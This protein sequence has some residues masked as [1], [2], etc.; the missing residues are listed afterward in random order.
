MSAIKLTSAASYFRGLSHQ[1]A[2]WNWL[3]EQL[4]PQQL[5]E[6]AE[7]YRADPPANQRPQPPG[8]WLALCAPLVQSFEGCRLTAYPD[9]GT[10]GDPWTI[11]WGSTTYANGKPVKPGDRIDQA[12][13]DQLLISRLQRDWQTLA[14]RI[15]GWGRMR[16]GQQAAL[17][18]F[19]YNV[20]VGFY[21][22]S[23]FGTISRA[24]SSQDWASV[25][26]A[27]MLYVNPGTSVEAG[28]RR[29]RIAEGTT[30]G[31]A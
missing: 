27:L 20:G 21:Q 18:S 2:A 14:G 28:L 25:P 24:L 5:A 31:K 13:A 1:I 15:P 6:F 22:S 3:E 9:P 16:P 8:N 10:G 30:W 19:A 26:S 12:Q 17:V 7:L 11:G 29:R 23:G 4:Q